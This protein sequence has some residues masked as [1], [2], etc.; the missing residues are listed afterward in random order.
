[1][2][3][4][5]GLGKQFTLPL[6]INEFTI[7]YMLPFCFQGCYVLDEA[8]LLVLSVKKRELGKCSAFFSQQGGNT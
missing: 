8:E 2:F 6:L 7:G 1:M 4:D 3:F 5:A